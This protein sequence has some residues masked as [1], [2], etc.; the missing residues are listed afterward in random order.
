MSFYHGIVASSFRRFR[1]AS[2]DSE[3]TQYLLDKY[4]GAKLAYSMRRLRADYAGGCIKVRRASDDLLADIP[5]NSDTIDTTAL[6]NHLSGSDGFLHTYY[7]QDAALTNWVQT[8]PLL[9][10][11]IALAGN[12]IMKDGYP[13]IFSQNAS[14]FLT[15]PFSTTSQTCLDI[16]IASHNGTGVMVAYDGQ[17]GLDGDYYGVGR[18]SGSGLDYGV[19]SPLYHIDNTELISRQR[20]DFL[21]AVSGDVLKVIS[22]SNLNLENFPGYVNNYTPSTSYT[23]LQYLV[24]KVVYPSSTGREAIQTEIN[25]YYSII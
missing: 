6:A 24:E 2:P 4:P 7:G 3:P 18:T 10:P 5:F 13:A 14:V 22:I 11:Q 17:S 9:Q 20:V 21:N 23:P 25:N 16:S 15:T 1:A 19:G 12:I 8:D